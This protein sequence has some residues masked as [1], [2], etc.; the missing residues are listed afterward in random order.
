MGGG[1]VLV[2]PGRAVGTQE[3]SFPPVHC[4]GGKEECPA[5]FMT[6]AQGPWPGDALG[7]DQG[8]MGNE[9][10]PGPKPHQHLPLKTQ[11]FLSNQC[12]PSQAWVGSGEA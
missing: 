4:S 7:N 12:E 5:C 2:P 9:K 1:E 11:G 3:G 10:S 8:E 6:L